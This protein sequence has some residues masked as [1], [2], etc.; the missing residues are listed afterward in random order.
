[1]ET[2]YISGL[3]VDNLTRQDIIDDLPAYLASDKKMIITSVNPQ[4]AM[5]VEQYPEVRKYIQ[6]A[7]HRLP[8]GVGVVKMSKYLGGNIRERVTG[9]DVM[10]D[11]LHYADAHGCRI[12]LYGAKKEVVKKAAANIA[13]D[14]PNLKVVGYIDG[15]TELSGDEITT[16]INAVHPD[17]LFVALGSPKQELFLEEQVDALNAKVYLDVGGTFDVLSGTVKRAPQFFIKLNL[18]WLYRSLK[19]RR[20]ERLI[21][22]L[23]YMVKSWRMRG[24]SRQMAGNKKPQVGTG[25]SLKTPSEQASDR[26]VKKN[27]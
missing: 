2:E 22:I 23:Q 20:P 3:P 6:R 12:F 19:Y 25:K 27:S 9:I 15:Y 10:D 5:Q 21:Q 7:T 24:H 26:D 1:M 8:D 18:E 17:F 13:A 16:R 4:I 11:C 14:Y